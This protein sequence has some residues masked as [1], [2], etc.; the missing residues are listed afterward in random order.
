MNMICDQPMMQS[1]D[2]ADHPICHFLL[3]VLL[4]IDQNLRQKFDNEHLEFE[5]F[6][7]TVSKNDIWK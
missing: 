6:P 7:F 5:H 2:V 3:K 4:S 1:R